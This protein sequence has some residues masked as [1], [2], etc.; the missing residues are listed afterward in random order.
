MNIWVRSDDGVDD[1]DGWDMRDGDG[2]AGGEDVW[3]GNGN[4]NGIGE[5][6]RLSNASDNDSFVKNP[7]ELQY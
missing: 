3:N 6:F 2:V 7:N 4:G 5:I 1:P